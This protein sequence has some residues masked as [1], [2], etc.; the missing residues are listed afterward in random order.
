MAKK[1]NKKL[2]K[3]NKKIKKRKK[4]LR[5]KKRKLLK[6]IKKIKN[7]ESKELIFKV[8]KKWSKSAYV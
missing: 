3:K 2:K 8:S 5:K 1:K 6:R 7:S 4:K